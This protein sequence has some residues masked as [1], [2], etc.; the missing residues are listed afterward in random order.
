MKTLLN[1]D[2]YIASLYR[3]GLISKQECHNAMQV[4][5]RVFFGREL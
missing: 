1:A 3:S 4:I 5:N 2:S